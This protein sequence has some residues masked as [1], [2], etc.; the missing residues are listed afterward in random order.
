[1]TTCRD[2]LNI[3]GREIKHDTERLLKQKQCYAL[4]WLIFLEKIIE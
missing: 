2:T 4:Y 1:M 3:K